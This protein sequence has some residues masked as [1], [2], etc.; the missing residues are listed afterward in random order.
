MNLFRR[1]FCLLLFV[2]LLSLAAQEG[3]NHQHV[4][5]VLDWSYR[6]LVVS[7]GL[8]PANLEAAKMEPR[9]LFHLAGRNLHREASSSG[10][11]GDGSEND[12]SPSLGGSPFVIR[13]KPPLRRDWSVSLGAGSVA[14]N[15]FPAKYSF[16]INANPDCLTTMRCLL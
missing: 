4:G 2:P 6:H 12:L 5:R 14:P 7:G 9:I 16:D 10:Q 1:N 11:A 8:S 13:K 15:N 3:P